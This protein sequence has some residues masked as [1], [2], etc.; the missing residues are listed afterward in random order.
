MLM[1]DYSS[2]EYLTRHLY[3][4]NAFVSS[5]MTTWRWNSGSLYQQIGGSV[6]VTLILGLLSVV[7]IFAPKSQARTDGLLCLDVPPGEWKIDLVLE[8]SLSERFGCAISVCSLGL[9]IGLLVWRR[10][11][12]KAKRV[13]E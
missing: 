10:D 11:G 9:V 12:K 4:R 2:F 5:D 7:T 8:S 1:Q 3:Y 6:S 13:L